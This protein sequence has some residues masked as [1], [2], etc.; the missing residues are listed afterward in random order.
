MILYGG[1]RSPFVRKVE[2]WI[3][4]QGRQVERR[5]VNAFATDFDG[6]TTINPLGRVPALTIDTGESLFESSAIIDYLEDTAEPTNRLLPATGPARRH[7]LQVMA[8]SHGISEK[9][10]ALY[11]ETKRRPA[12]YQWNEWQERLSTQIRNGLQALEAEIAMDG[13]TPTAVEIAA[14]CAYDINTV[15]FPELVDPGLAY[16]KSLSERANGH[17][18]FARTY[19]SPS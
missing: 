1:R 16:L 11:Y 4:A 10:I 17:P 6:L 3:A 13:P 14:C 9:G 12:Q 5:Y 7:I 15:T 2:L 18:A 8:L 19:P